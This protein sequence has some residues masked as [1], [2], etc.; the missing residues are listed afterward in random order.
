M[1]C[2]SMVWIHFSVHTSFYCQGLT[3]VSRCS[4]RS[5]AGSR[6]RERRFSRFRPFLVH[7]A[8]GGREAV[9]YHPDLRPWQSKWKLTVE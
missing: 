6:R 2:R 8:D 9:A 1:V 7:P 3:L 5:G 4:Q